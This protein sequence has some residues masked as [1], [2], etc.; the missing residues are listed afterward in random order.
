VSIVIPS[1]EAGVDPYRTANLS[2]LRTAIG[3]QTFTDTELLVVEAVA[4][5]G[6]AINQGVERARGEYLVVFD[7]DSSVDDPELLAKL[8][9]ALD[10]DPTI[11]MAGASVRTP[12]AA[13][14]FQRIAAREF[15]RF[16]VPVV[17]V[18]TDSDLAC[19]GC[20]A[21]PLVLFRTLGGEREQIVRGLDPDLRQRIRG[22]GHRVVL[23]PDT[24]V[25]HP[26]PRSLRS[27][28]RT[29]RRNGAGSAYAQMHHPEL[30]Y[31]TDEALD[32][33]G[34]VARRS[35]AYR[36]ARF[37]LRIAWAL[38]TLRPI[39]AF[40]Y[41]NYALGYFGERL[42]GKTPRAST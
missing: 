3:Q 30:V 4:P 13:G 18:V 28:A 7:D 24:V 16:N 22:S 27:L 1:L 2:R 38:L 35:Y 32:S 36:V 34:F 19:H 12:A 23:V 26:L 42:R 20:A 17:E 8:V 11:G 25:Y 9:H 21:F 10:A 37:P 6:R 29:F 39:R 40:A 33:V 31:E 41:S 15:P 14:L 5:Q